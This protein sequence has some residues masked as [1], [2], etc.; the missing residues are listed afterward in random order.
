M[1]LKLSFYG[2]AENVTG[3][4]YLLEANGTRVMIDCGMYQERKL[5][6]RNWDAFQVPPA[7]ID[8]ILL[9]HGHLDHCGLIPRLVNQG[10]NG[11]I[12]C[13]SPTADI[14]AII[15]QDSAKIQEE[16]VR[17]KKKRHAR[18]GR[19]SPHPLDAESSNPSPCHFWPTPTSSASATFC[20]SLV[21]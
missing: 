8:A 6:D 20:H 16:D 19:Q 9:T 7:S 13:T 4:R 5:R 10:F 12:Y 11:P 1:D 17:H 21:C 18:E 2:A 15:M 3:S 14:A